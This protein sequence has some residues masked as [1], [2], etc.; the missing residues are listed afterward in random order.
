MRMKLVIAC[1]LGLR[2]VTG[3]GR[4][5]WPRLE[6]YVRWLAEQVA[7]RH[8]LWSGDLGKAL[9]PL[10]APHCF[11]WGCSEQAMRRDGPEWLRR[12]A[13]EIVGVEGELA[14]VGGV[15][16]WRAAAPL[17]DEAHIA[18]VR[19]SFD[20]EGAQ[21]V[22]H[23]E[24]MPAGEWIHCGAQRREPEGGDEYGLTTVV[25]RRRVAGKRLRAIEGGATC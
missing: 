11:T 14:V 7:G 15:E 9:H 10:V 18:L 25:M 12:R 16:A 1:D 13:R 23:E 6:G 22:P 17:A 19:G 20:V 2:C 5:P 3:E 21:V 24:L 8:A 4:L